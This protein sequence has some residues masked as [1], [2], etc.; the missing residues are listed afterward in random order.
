MCKADYL[1]DDERATLITALRAEQKGSRSDADTY[2]RE[3]RRLIRKLE[4]WG[5][6]AR[7]ARAIGPYVDHGVGAHG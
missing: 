2:Q 7:P 6:R 5:E 4:N 3:L 1:H